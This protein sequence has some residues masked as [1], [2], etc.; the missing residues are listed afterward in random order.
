M[1]ENGYKYC[2]KNHEFSVQNVVKKA[3]CETFEIDFG[4]S[5]GVTGK[6][7]ELTKKSFPSK[8]VPRKLNL[9]RIPN[10]AKIT[11]RR[12][13]KKVEK[14]ERNQAIRRISSENSRNSTRPHSVGR[15]VERGRVARSGQGS[16]SYSGGEMN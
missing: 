7:P 10:S 16:G 12:P 11:S 14:D 8:V 15:F 3:G 6:K 2:D 1:Q 13:L 9:D 4:I 5:G